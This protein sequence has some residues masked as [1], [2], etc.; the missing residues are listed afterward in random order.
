M[1]GKT[2]PRWIDVVRDVA[3]VSVR[4]A[5]RRPG[6]VDARGAS[7]VRALSFAMAFGAVLLGGC[8]KARLDE[9]VRR[10]CEKDGGITVHETVRMPPERF[11]AYGD[12]WVSAKSFAKPDD[13]YFSTSDDTYLRRG[14]PEMVRYHYRVIRRSDGKVLGEGVVYWR[15]G[16]DMPGPWHDSAFM[17][18]ERGVES[19]LRKRIFVMD[20]GRR[21]P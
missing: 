12:L 15:R 21:E 13:E 3:G 11:D 19:Q 10:L 14:N 16:G 4:W 6:A 20:R 17:C 2:R 9:Q 8:E 7:I 1:V 5:R 18:P